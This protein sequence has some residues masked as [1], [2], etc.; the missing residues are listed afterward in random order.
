MKDFISQA[1]E[2]TDINSTFT[3]NDGNKIP[4]VGFGTWK[5]KENE[6][7]EQIIVDAINSGFRHFDIAALYKSET[8]IGK[9]IK[10]Q[11][12]HVKSFL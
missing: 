9:A 12:F 10:N 8:S 11:G 1:K 6:N 4:C 3:L 2:F 5:I 7:G